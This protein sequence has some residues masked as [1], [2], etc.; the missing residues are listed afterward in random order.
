MVS[1]GLRR[2]EVLALTWSDVDLNAGQLRVRRNLQRIK[3]ELLF[4]TP[5]TARSIRTVSLP[6]RCVD[7]LHEHRVTQEQERKVAGPKWKPLEHQPGGLI[8]TT[9][10]GRATDPRSLNRM[11]TLLC[12]KARVRRVR[13]HDLRHTCASLLLAQGV[14]ARIIMETLGH[15]TITMTLDTYAH[16]MQTT[17]RAAADR[18]DDALGIDGLGEEDDE[19]PEESSAE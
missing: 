4:G 18:M 15:S 2:G 9:S 10:T 13:V 6:K 8:P 5:K 17:L 3:R 16:V 14:D 12:A 1:T 7:A 19:A 11:L